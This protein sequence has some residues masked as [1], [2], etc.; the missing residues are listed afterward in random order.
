VTDVTDLDVVRRYWRDLWGGTDLA[1]VDEIFGETYVRHNRN[2][3]E[4]LTRA[5][6]KA[7]FRRYWASFGNAAAVRVDHVSVDRSGHVWSRVN[8]SGRDGDSGE[9]RV[10]TFLHESRLADGLI[11]ETWT[12]TAPD[13]DWR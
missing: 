1:L 13:V 8:I 2:G 12:L 5:K 11:V 6:L 10:V 4:R 7:D 9:V 3:T